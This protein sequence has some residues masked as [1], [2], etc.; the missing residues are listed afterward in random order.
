MGDLRKGQCGIGHHN[1]RI[2]DLSKAPVSE[3]RSG[4]GSPARLEY[5]IPCNES[6]VVRSCF[7]ETGQ[8][9]DG[10]LW[11]PNKLAADDI[12]NLCQGERSACTRRHMGQGFCLLFD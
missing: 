5:P 10:G 2:G 11:R 12:V 8:A 7:F 1:V 4:S 3:E 9:R 6:Q